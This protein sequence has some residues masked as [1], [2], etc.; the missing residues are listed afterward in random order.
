[1][2]LLGLFIFLPL[3][4]CKVEVRQEFV[5]S[6]R[7]SMR[8]EIITNDGSRPN[9]MNFSLF[10]RAPKTNTVHLNTFDSAFNYS[11]QLL[12]PFTKQALGD[13]IYRQVHFSNI[14]QPWFNDTFTTSSGIVL[15]IS[16][17]IGCTPHYYGSQC[18]VFCDGHL[19]KAARKRCDAMGRLRCDIGWMGPHCGQAVDPR[20]CSCQNNGICAS[21]MIHSLDKI[22]NNTE[23]LICE[24]TNGYTGNHCEVPGF[25]QFQFT[26]PQPDACSVKDACL[27]GAKCFPN[28]PKVFCACAVG[29]IGEFCEISLTTTTP[30]VEITASTSDYSVTI[31]SVVGIFIGLCL[32]IGC[33]KYKLT[34]R[35]EHALARGLV[36]E[37]YPMPE[38]KS[39]LVD[40]EACEAENQ[41]NKKVFTIGDNVKQVDEEVRYTSAPRISNDY[42]VIQKPPPPTVCLPRIPV[43]CV[44]V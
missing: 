6:E 25:T 5:T 21:S 18:E 10:P 14:N 24:C 28:G 8:F 1:M 3:I 4:T 11:I 40:Q 41:K 26:A 23:Q 22:Q 13:R 7:V 2:L 19:A 43:T 17:R 42:A 12:Q 39:M 44:Y 36:P 29:F 16:T 38:T 15:S 32:L 20:K 33:C 27:N 34:H 30:S 31:Y 9:P 35:R 37:P